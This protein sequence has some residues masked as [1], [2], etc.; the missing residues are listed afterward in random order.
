MTKKIFEPIEIKGMKLKNR[1]SIPAWLLSPV[2]P[3]GTA[4][5][6]TIRW[7]EK[8]AKGGVGLIITGTISCMK[9]PAEQAAVGAEGQML[10]L[11]D[12]KF[13]PGWAKLVDVIH[14]YGTKICA[15]FALPGPLLGLSP[16]PPPFPDDTHAKFSQFDLMAG[17]IIPA[18]E[19]SPEELH[20]LGLALAGA[21]GR[22]KAAG[23][24]SVEFHSAHGGANLH[25]AL[26]SPFFN[27]RT[28]MYG[29]S[30]ANRLRYHVE[31]IENIRKVVG[32]NYP[33]LVR[34]TGDDLLGK[35]GITIE[36]TVKYV[37]PTLEKAGIDAFDV[38]QGSILH[39]PQGISIPL[40]YP[41]GCFIHN[42]AAIKKASKVPVIGVGRVIDLDMAERFLQEGQADII[43]VGSQLMCDPETPNK[44]FEGKTEDIRKCI[45]DKPAL[46]G[47]PCILNY[48]SHDD[49]IPLKPAEKQ[50]KVLVIGGGVAGMEAA[51]VATLRGHKVTLVEK[52]PELGGMV[53]TLAHNPLTAEFRNI[54]DYLG[55]QLRKLQV[56]VR[57]CKE[58]NA[59]SI[60]EL[61]P[62]VVIVAAGSSP[63]IPE[64]A[65]GKP[66][67]MTLDAALKEQEAIGQRV[68]VL[69]Y[70][71]A[72]LAITL[73][74]KGK[75]VILIGKG[76]EGTIGSDLSDSR[77]FWLLKK[78]TDI[79]IVRVSPD[80]MTLSNPRVL[81]N[82]D[83][84]DIGAREVRVVNKDGEKQVLPC[85]TVIL[86]RRFGERKSNDSL[87][88]E[89]KDKVAESYKIGDCSKVKGI[90]EAILSANE[91]ARKI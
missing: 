71:G 59:T 6:Q 89:L 46:C 21:C 75:D 68:V 63:T 87:F 51:R 19:V 26:L 34:I 47:R 76:N 91:V 54:V 7:Y 35:N 9:P 42:A 69:G 56:D 23:F 44:Y 40:Y 14:S 8:W 73:A 83:I 61:K 37:V 32:N 38:S 79:N 22:A 49:P 33:I 62:D 4:G 24:D 60:K 16:S 84:D 13:I 55:I 18:K 52:E 74:G 41:R 86:A 29:G 85:D 48:D 11:E 27:R 78:L 81:S 20:F 67:V 12:D 30:W 43:N 70:F 82:S 39:S 10:T 36:D 50:K 57:V 72:E 15:Q 90:Y 3:G 80:E 77:H 66:G 64:V 58:A 25:S 45:G 31:T 88:N 53:A 17:R 2:G 5:D 65:K 28:D 1:L